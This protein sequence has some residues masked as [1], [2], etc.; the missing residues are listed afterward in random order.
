MSDFPC[1]IEMGIEKDAIRDINKFTLRQEG[2][3]DILKIYFKRKPGSLLASSRKFRIGR[4]EHTVRVKDNPQGYVEAAPMSPFLMKAV[5]ELNCLVKQ[6]HNRELTKQRLIEDIEHLE[7]V[8]SNKLAE[9]R[10][11]LEALD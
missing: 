6:E 5:D 11:D 1:L 10:Q 2:K 4:A 3:E 8:M 9:L 7:K